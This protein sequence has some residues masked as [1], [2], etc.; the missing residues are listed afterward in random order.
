MDRTAKEANIAAEA[1][2]AEKTREISTQT[3]VDQS[4]QCDLSQG[5]SDDV[6]DKAPLTFGEGGITRFSC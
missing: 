4:T 6:I 2:A 5:D 3:S 1:K